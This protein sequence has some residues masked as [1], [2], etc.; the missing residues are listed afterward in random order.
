MTRLDDYQWLFRKAPAMATSI[1]E[2]GSYLDV[3]DAFLR[4]LGYKREEMIG[5][6]KLDLVK[7]ESE[8]RIKEEL[9]NEIRRTGKIEKKTISMVTKSGDVVD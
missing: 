2:D 4:R 6:Q 9:R 5:R 7:K 1:A 8:R 3:N